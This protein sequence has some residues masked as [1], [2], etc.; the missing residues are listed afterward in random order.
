MNNDK[1]KPNKPIISYHDISYDIYAEENYYGGTKEHYC[2]Q[3]NR[4]FNSPKLT[5]DSK[6]QSMQ[7]EATETLFIG[8]LSFNIK[9]DDLRTHF[10][11]YGTILNVRMAVDRDTGKFRGYIIFSYF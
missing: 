7:C 5:N 4:D 11:T 1:V 10:S 2:D 9:E 8:G 6:K 3:E